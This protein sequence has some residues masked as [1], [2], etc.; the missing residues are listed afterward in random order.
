MSKQIG[1]NFDDFL[2]EEGVL[3]EVEDIAVK[4]VL[5]YQL[6]KP[7]KIQR[8]NKMRLAKNVKTS[9][10]ALER[11]LNPEGRGY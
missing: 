9:R 11:L 7:M 6:Q 5:A 2:E 10:F 8:L 3:A 1:S 4:R